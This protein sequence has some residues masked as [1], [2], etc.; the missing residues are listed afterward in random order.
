MKKAEFYKKCYERSDDSTKSLITENKELKRGEQHPPIM[1]I[2][3]IILDLKAAESD[4]RELREEMVE[5]KHKEEA[6]RTKLIERSVYF[7]RLSI[8][9]Q[10]IR[11]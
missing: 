7:S 4:L 9:T 10:L 5:T 11:L 3:L 2:K 1:Q 6:K 8:P